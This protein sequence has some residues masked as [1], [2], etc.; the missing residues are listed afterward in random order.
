MA[1]THPQAPQNAT[2]PPMPNAQFEPVE[3]LDSGSF[4]LLLPVRSPAE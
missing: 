3:L 2:S 1:W 4:R